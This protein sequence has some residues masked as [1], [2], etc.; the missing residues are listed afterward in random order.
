M[1]YPE[2]LHLA[3]AP[4][5]P[6][7]EFLVAYSTMSVEVLQ[8]QLS[9]AEAKFQSATQLYAIPG[10][11][12][13]ITNWIWPDV[14]KVQG[15]LQ[16]RIMQAMIDPKSHGHQAQVE[17]H[18][19]ANGQQEITAVRVQ[20]PEEFQKVLVVAYRPNQLWVNRKALSPA[21]KF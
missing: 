1:A 3:L 10:K 20:F 11:E 12:M 19:D 4:Q 17:I 14:K 15:L 2:A 13:A 5:L 7:P 9:Q 6:F 21:I 8:K 18:A 16:G